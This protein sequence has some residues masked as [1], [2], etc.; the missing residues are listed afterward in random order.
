MHFAFPL[1]LVGLISI[2]LFIAGN[3]YARK[4][5]ALYGRIGSENGNTR[6][7]LFRQMLRFTLGS[8]ALLFATFTIA[9]PRYAVTFHDPMKAGIDI[10]IVLDISKSMLAEDVEPNRIEAAK[11]NISEFVD[12]RNTDRIGLIV[13]AGKPFGLSPL[14]FDHDSLQTIIAKMGTESIRQELEGLSGTNIG[15]ALLLALQNLK[16]AESSDAKREK[17]ILL[18]TDGEANLGIDPRLVAIRSKEE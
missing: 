4:K 6:S 8:L 16:N 14:T 9:E 18:V 11:R 15:D 13:F 2:P 1:A 7:I 17:I 10:A 12:S 3:L 5:F